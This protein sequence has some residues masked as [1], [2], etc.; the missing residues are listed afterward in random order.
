MNLM[1]N[2]LADHINLSFYQAA[3][4]LSPSLEL[5]VR[6]SRGRSSLWNNVPSNGTP[7]WHW[8]KQEPRRRISQMGRGSIHLTETTRKWNVVPLL[9]YMAP[10]GTWR[11]A[12]LRFRALVEAFQLDDQELSNKVFP[13]PPMMQFQAVKEILLA[14]DTNRLVAELTF[15]ARCETEDT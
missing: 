2:T 8:P 11:V 9:G 15:D 12:D 13:Y 4:Q 6:L 5:G 10:Y 14:R 7:T 3:R 1:L